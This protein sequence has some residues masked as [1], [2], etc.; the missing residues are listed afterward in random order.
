MEKRALLQPL[1][2]AGG[3]SCG[4]AAALSVVRGKGTASLKREEFY[5]LSMK[6]VKFPSQCQKTSQDF[7]EL[8]CPLELALLGLVLMLNCNARVV[9]TSMVHL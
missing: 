3:G 5:T 8:F 4:S 1:S 7:N 2:V 9:T 6:D